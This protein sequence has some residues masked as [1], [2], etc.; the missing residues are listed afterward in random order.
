MMHK[1]L[2]CIAKLIN[3]STLT[4]K[5]KLRRVSHSMSALPDQCTEMDR[6]LFDL[7][8][9]TMVIPGSH[10]SNICHPEL[11]RAAISITPTSVDQVTG[12]VE[13]F[14]EPGEA[15]DALGLSLRATYDKWRDETVLLFT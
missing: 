15:R 5:S 7:N 11:Q 13:V 8:G 3:A 14:L 4:Y 10:K 9:A 1:L 2:L 12:A 6:C